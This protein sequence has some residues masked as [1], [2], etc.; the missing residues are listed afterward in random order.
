MNRC[1]PSDN[2]DDPWP[3]SGGFERDVVTLVIIAVILSSVGSVSE[4]VSVN[5]DGE[6]VVPDCMYATVRIY[7]KWYIETNHTHVFNTSTILDFN[8][9][10]GYVNENGLVIAHV[11]VSPELFDAYNETDYLE[12]WICRDEKITIDEWIDE[13]LITIIEGQLP[14]G[15]RGEL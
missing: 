7:D 12:G 15:M 4:W 6:V 1:S 3:Y 10:D 11:I 9:D 14:W 8:D 5:D 2:V 13:R